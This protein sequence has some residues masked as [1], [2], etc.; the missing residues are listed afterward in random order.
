MHKCFLISYLGSFRKLKA[1]YFE[2]TT[3]RV[4]IG[5]FILIFKYIDEPYQLVLS[6]NVGL[7]AIKVVSW[8]SNYNFLN[9]DKQFL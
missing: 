3:S 9:L 6:C 1:R 7:I 4:V 8:L 2:D 5:P